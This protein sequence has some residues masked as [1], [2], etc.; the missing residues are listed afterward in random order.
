M[1]Q[2]VKTPKVSKNELLNRLPLFYEMV[3]KNEDHENALKI[4]QLMDKLYHSEFMIGFC[5]HFSAG[6]SSMINHLVGENL[7]P[8]S[9]IPTSANLV[10]VRSGREYARIYY[11]NG[12]I[13]EYPENYDYDLIKSYCKDGES[14]DSIVISHKNSHLPQDVTIMDTPGIDST[15]VAHRLSTE[16]A[17]HLADVL[18]YVMDY[19]HV[20]SELNFQ[21]TKDLTD[22]HKTLYLIVNQIDKHKESELSF[23][24]F[25]EGVKE[26]FNNWNVSYSNIFFTTLKGGN[27]DKNELEDVKSLLLEKIN[28]KDELLLDGVY[29]AAQQIILDHLAFLDEQNSG[30]SERHKEILSILTPAEKEL[31][32]KTI[33]DL[34]EEINQLQ[35]E[36]DDIRDSYLAGV[37]KLITNA[38]LMPFQTR[39]L[40]RV[41]LESMQ[42]DFK[43]GLLFSKNKTERE[44]DDR[45]QRFF[46]DL[47]EKISTSLEWHLKEFIT[48]AIKDANMNFLLSKVQE[49]SVSIQP[50]DLDKLRKPSARP[51]GEYILTYTNDV[52]NEIK[53][54]Y[55]QVAINLLN[56]L[57]VHLQNNVIEQ[58]KELKVELNQYLEYMDSIAALEKLKRNRNELRQSL[59]E[60]LTGKYQGRN[61]NIADFIAEFI[62]EEIEI[63]STEEILNEIEKRQV[64]EKRSLEDDS[65]SKGK[66]L[67]G[68][69][70]ANKTIQH[71]KKA[72]ELI[73]PITGLSTIAN[74]MKDKASRLENNQF[75][76]AL[77]GAFSAGKSSFANALMGEQ[78][79]PVSPNPTT[80]T[81]N[82]ITF[83]TT[84]HQHGTVVVK[85]KSEQQLL[86]DI[87]HSLQVFGEKAHSLDESLTLIRIRMSNRTDIN[88]KEKPHY[89]F[90]NAVIDG[91]EHISNHIGSCLTIT[92]NE[93]SEFVA[94][95]DKACFVEWIE[96]YYDCPLTK[97]GITLVD[98]PGADSINARHTG[99][100]F[101]YIKNADAVLFVTYYNHA[102]SQAD[103]EFLIQLG[104]VK[105]TFSMDKMFF[106][107]NAADLANSPNELNEV[108]DY[109]EGELISYGIRL[110]RLYPISSRVALLEKQKESTE[111]EKGIL[112]SSGIDK[113]EHDFQS[114]IIEEL[115]EVAVTA[116]YAEMERAYIVV[117]SY[118]ESAL[119]SK[120][121]KETKLR[122][123]TKQL[124]QIKSI[125]KVKDHDLQVGL[126]EQEI[127]EL[128]YYI[129]RRVFIRLP[130][131]F[132]EAFNP[133][134]LKDDGGDIKKALQA[135]LGEML[136]AFGFDLSQE[137][138]ATSLRIEKFISKLFTEMV[139]GLNKEIQM[140]HSSVTISN[141]TDQKFNKIEFNDA[142]QD[143]DKLKYK[144][145]LAQ[146]RNP[147]V[148]FEKNG[149]REMLAEIE[150]LLQE[151]VDFYLEENKKFIQD[152]YRIQFRDTVNMLQEKAIREVN[153]YFE[154]VMKILTED[155]NIDYLENVKNQLSTIIN[156]R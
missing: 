95:E 109:V 127:K 10:K 42:S 85:L 138:R 50:I 49:M 17:L 51:T 129:K 15:D 19:N 75:T 89:S 64:E 133:T 125:I 44:R 93:F 13:I 43:V 150:G 155:V 100:A 99:V 69:T 82:K 76:V 79:L 107:I 92:M 103:R 121:V 38:N 68:K 106:I 152:T 97:Q 32:P 12:K 142:L 54:R 118:I 67:N 146:F 41:Y 14:V 115:T 1:I 111:K 56:E 58:E 60:I 102:F 144:K 39:E 11:K 134:S 104:R 98:T 124:E 74:D 116:A 137:L 8:S 66:V 63:S 18:F 65:N 16:S 108:Q 113:F 83:P 132:K 140:I 96:V 28:H 148:F 91:F 27:D 149:K 90:L 31:I 5:G 154:G 36:R 126:M 4:I 139:V 24:S 94:K 123:A 53:K 33:D 70:N 55:K 112:K 122:E 128:I 46:H 145:A 84:E 105:D 135:C 7:L 136:Q 72:E 21:F 62:K 130:D 73:K 77:F 156:V 131:L 20:L 9:P 59:Q 86:Q 2:T 37:D 143:E 110:P 23:S 141:L 80:A 71:L 114:F 147:K 35:I 61:V 6:K 120:D 52:S 25:Q 87:N 29:N 26:A 30:E 40:A 88:A 22:H 81:I 48:K 3:R 47:Q 34:K 153:D 45:H 101:E 57:V 117:E 151:P 78:I 119:E